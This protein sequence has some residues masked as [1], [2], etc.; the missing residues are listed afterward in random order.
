MHHWTEVISAHVHFM[1]F[2]FQ[3]ANVNRERRRLLTRRDMAHSLCRAHGLTATST[4]VVKVN[5][6]VRMKCVATHH[7]RTFHPS[8]F[9]VFGWEDAGDISFYIYCHLCWLTIIHGIFGAQILIIFRHFLPQEPVCLET[10][11]LG[12]A[13]KLRMIADST[14]D[15]W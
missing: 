5:R 11:Y 14:T 4:C 2:F 1:R 8:V 9:N 7:S 6:C 13:G 15:R 12:R 10:Q 3:Y